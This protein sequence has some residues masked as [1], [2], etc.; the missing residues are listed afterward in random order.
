MWALVIYAVA[1]VVCLTLMR[2]RPASNGGAMA[3]PHRGVGHDCAADSE[4]LSQSDGGVV[5]G[6]V[7]DLGVELRTDQHYNDRKPHPHHQADH[8]AECS[9]GGIVVGK[10]AE[11]PGEQRRHREPSEGGEDAAVTGAPSTSRIG[12]SIDSNM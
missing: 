11:I 7:L 12:V 6:L 3:R 2:L 4:R 5:C 1:M 9:V 8:R 10:I